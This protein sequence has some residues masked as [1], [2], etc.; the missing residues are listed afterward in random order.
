MSPACPTCPDLGTPSVL[1]AAIPTLGTS[2]PAL[3]VCP[4]ICLS[5]D[6][7]SFLAGLPCSQHLSPALGAPRVTTLLRVSSLSALSQRPGIA[8]AADGCQTEL[9]HLSTLSAAP[10]ARAGALRRSPPPIELPTRLPQTL[11]TSG[12]LQWAPGTLLSLKA[13]R[14]QLR[15][16]HQRSSPGQRSAAGDPRAW[17][18]APLRAPTGTVFP[19]WLPALNNWEILHQRP[20]FRP[21]LNGHR[22]GREGWL[23]GGVPRAPPRAPS[24]VTPSQ[25]AP[26]TAALWSKEERE[27]ALWLRF[28]LFWFFGEKWRKRDP[29][30]PRFQN[31]WERARFFVGV[32]NI[33]SC[34]L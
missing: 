25:A 24:A 32:M 17:R 16:S 10:G 5:C 8:P 28:C 22:G 1:P 11:K 23:R 27:R 30:S 2:C 21:V 12:H 4:C 29:G 6:T 26:H 3:R 9:P 31:N 15:A 20:D 19:C 14:A 34:L 7:R 18:R 13:H 33:P